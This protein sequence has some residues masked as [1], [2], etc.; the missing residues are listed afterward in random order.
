LDVIHV[1]TGNRRSASKLGV[2]REDFEHL[3]GSSALVTYRRGLRSNPARFG[4]QGRAIR[5][6]DLLT[7]HSWVARS[8][9][10]A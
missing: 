7:T 4:D 3:P 2:V 1:I 9:P 8:R 5:R 6:G 10:N